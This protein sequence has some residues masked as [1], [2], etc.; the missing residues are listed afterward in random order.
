MQRGTAQGLDCARAL[1]RPMS[2]EA[3]IWAKQ[4]LSRR[5][6][7]GRP[8]IKRAASKALLLYL[9]DEVRDGTKGGDGRTCWPGRQTLCEGMGFDRRTITLAFQELESV[10]LIKRYPRMRANGRGRKSDLIELF[11]PAFCCDPRVNSGLT[12][13]ESPADQGGDIPDQ[14][15]DLHP[16]PSRE[17]TTGT[18]LLDR[19]RQSPTDPSTGEECTPGPGGLR[20]LAMAELVDT[21][22]RRVAA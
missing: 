22:D 16:E 20:R 2:L 14:G 21:D 15:G 10:E 7:D 13:G 9:A 5:D 8:V 1:G 6:A 3:T 17:P 4:C 18:D 12:T 19:A 11:G